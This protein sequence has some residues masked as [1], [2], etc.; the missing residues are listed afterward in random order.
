MYENEFAE[1]SHRAVSK[2][3]NMEEVIKIDER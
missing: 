3:Q 1:F 2:T